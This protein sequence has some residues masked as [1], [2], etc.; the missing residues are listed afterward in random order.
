MAFAA[1]SKNAIV[2]KVIYGRQKSAVLSEQRIRS[3]S[4]NHLR[5]VIALSEACPE[6]RIIALINR[7]Q[8]AILDTSQSDHFLFS[9]LRVI[10]C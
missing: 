9:L 7:M 3:C 2:I 10:E 1:R 8:V 4:S 5:Y 6:A